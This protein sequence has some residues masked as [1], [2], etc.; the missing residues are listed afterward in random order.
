MARMIESIDDDVEE[1][2]DEMFERTWQSLKTNKSDK[3][4]FI[5]KA[6]HSLKKAILN[7]IF[8][9]LHGGQKN[10]LW[11]GTEQD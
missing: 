1:L 4:K 5:F 8:A 3:Y 9:K 7:S 10:V 11:Y 6:G 2:S